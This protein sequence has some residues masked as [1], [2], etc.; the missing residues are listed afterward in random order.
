M[1]VRAAEAGGEKQQRGGGERR[2]EGR[3]ETSKQ[4]PPRNNVRGAR[5]RVEGVIRINMGGCWFCFILT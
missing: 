2:T 5:Q 1:C 4:R 3:G